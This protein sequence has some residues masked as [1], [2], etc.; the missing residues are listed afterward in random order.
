MMSFSGL[1]LKQETPCINPMVKFDRVDQLSEY[2]YI[3]FFCSYYKLWRKQENILWPTNF[4]ISIRNRSAHSLHSKD[5]TDT[6]QYKICSYHL[7][8]PFTVALR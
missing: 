4:D 7:A 1:V 6:C 2:V 3:S 5:K 8:T